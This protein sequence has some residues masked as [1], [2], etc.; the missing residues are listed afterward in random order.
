MGRSK[1]IRVNILVPIYVKR[2]IFSQY[3]S[4]RNFPS[5]KKKKEGLHKVA[6]FNFNERTLCTYTSKEGRKHFKHQTSYN[7]NNNTKLTNRTDC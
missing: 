3:F 1:W 7:L 5:I 6:K 4:E 2:T